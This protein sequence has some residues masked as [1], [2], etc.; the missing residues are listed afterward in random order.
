MVVLTTGIEIA[1]HNLSLAHASA[2]APALVASSRWVR[3]ALEVH[4]T[5]RTR[6]RRPSRLR[7]MS[8]ILPQPIALS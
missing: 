6:L 7:R 5:R 1:R 2:A 4:R 3:A 8:K